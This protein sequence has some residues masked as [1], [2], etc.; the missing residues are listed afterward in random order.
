MAKKQTADKRLSQDVHIRI[1]D[2]EMAFLQK[3][4]DS[5]GVPVSRFIRMLV[6]KGSGKAGENTVNGEGAEASSQLVELKAMFKKMNKNVSQF[7]V[8]YERA[9]ALKNKDGNPAV[10]TDYTVRIVNNIIYLLRETQTKL[11]DVIGKIGGSE[12]HVVAN[13]PAGTVLGNYAANA[14]TGA[15]TVPVGIPDENLDRG[16]LQEKYRTMSQSTYTGIIEKAPEQFDAGQY[17]KMRLVIRVDGDETSKESY[18]VDYVDFINRYSKMLPYLTVGVKVFAHGR[19]S[20]KTGTYNG[21]KSD[22]KATLYLHDLQFEKLAT[23]TLTGVIEK[24]PEQFESGK[25]NKFRIVIRVDEGEGTAKE[26]Y[27]IDCVDFVRRC[28]GVIP[29]LNVGTK[30][31]VNGHL[32]FKAD[33][34]NGVKS[35][36]YATMSMYDILLV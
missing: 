32:V 28:S 30:V 36:S 11:N 22:S 13:P 24:A 21:V 6:F 2:A 20:L 16:K 12:V 34:Y 4:A 1:T 33:V 10:S 14:G 8:A 29:H 17:K 23:T 9:L 27:N 31:V 7:T 5:F 15:A 35:D 3:Q 19:F 26:S 18:C 25:Y